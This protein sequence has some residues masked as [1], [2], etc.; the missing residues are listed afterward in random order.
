MIDPKK[1]EKDSPEWVLAKFLAAWKRR[2]W[3][4]MAD[5]TQLSWLDI[6][7]EPVEWLKL[8]FSTRLIDASLMQINAKT[9]VVA[10]FLIELDVGEKIVS[11]I[12]LICEEAPMR[13]SPYG[14]WGVNPTSIILKVKT[15]PEEQVTLPDASTEIKEE[16]IFV[17]KKVEKKRNRKTKEIKGI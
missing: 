8:A 17:E 7:K 12:K 4:Q 16:D 9:G 5:Y 2:D 10:E 13:P 11:R 3:K 6:Y 1:Y 15:I 14:K